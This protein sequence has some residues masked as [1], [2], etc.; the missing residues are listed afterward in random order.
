MKWNENES[1]VLLIISSNTFFFLIYLNEIESTNWQSYLLH[2]FA[3]NQSVFLL[4]FW[5]NNR[6]NPIEIIGDTSENSWYF[7]FTTETKWCDTN[8]MSQCWTIRENLKWPT[9]ISRA[10]F[11][12]RIICTVLT[13]MHVKLKSWFILQSFIKVRN[14]FIAFQQRHGFQLRFLKFIYTSNF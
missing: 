12:Y 10:T 6:F 1:A 14:C 11:Y 2:P 3:S 7:H 13:V 8:N 4:S 9:V 5:P